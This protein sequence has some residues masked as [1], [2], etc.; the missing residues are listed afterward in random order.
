MP[1]F[2]ELPIDG[3][4]ATFLTALDRAMGIDPARRRTSGST[5]TTSAQLA[6][7]GL[8]IVTAAG[9]HR[10]VWSDPELVG[11]LDGI[12]A[13]RAAPDADELVDAIR[14]RGA[15]PIGRSVLHVVHRRGLRPAGL[16]EGGALVDLEH[17]AATAALRPLLDTAPPVD[18]EVAGFGDDPRP[19]RVTVALDGTQQSVAA[20][21]RR[22]THL[23]DGVVDLGVLTHPQRRGEGWAGA[24]LAHGTHAVLDGGA[25]PLYR[26]EA[27]HE[28]ALQLASRLGYRRAAELHVLRAT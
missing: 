17:A 22:A 4:V 23:S 5:L 15:E 11:R 16:P 19:A 2:G 8:V 1:P 18:V 21:V 24:V 6:D 13:P 3:V 27:T 10:V 20:V 25:I 9:R 12:V 14:D 7:S 26:C 28:P